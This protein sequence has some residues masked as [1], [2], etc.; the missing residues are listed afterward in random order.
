MSK[1]VEIVLPKLGESIL[2]ATVVQWLKKEGDEI[3]LDEAIVEVST[4]KVNSEIPSPVAGVLQK[5]CVSEGVEVEV[6]GL[7]AVVQT[8]EAGVTT[9]QEAQSIPKKEEPQASATNTSSKFYTPVVLK[10]AKEKG[11]SEE[12]LASIKRSGAGGRLSRKDL[13]KY[14]AEKGEAC[15]A[16]AADEK[17]IKMGAM[18]KMIAQNLVKSFYEAPHA[19]LVFD[20]DITSTMQF[21][22]KEKEAFLKE[23]GF[24]LTITAFLAQAIAKSVVKFPLINSSLKGDTILVKSNVNLGIAVSVTEGVI[25][26]VIQ[27]CQRLGIVDIAREVAKLASLSRDEKLSPDQVKEGTITMTNFGMSGAM[28]GIPII[29]FPEVA[30]VGVGSI[31]KEASVVDGEIVIRDK[32]KLSLTFDHR[33]IDGI[34][35]CDFLSEVKEFFKNSDNIRIS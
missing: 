24:K 25:V 27:H 21:I 16:V 19:S 20:I 7:I 29:R 8:A 22:K 11:V 35:G 5:I 32:V 33:V 34:Y 31:D 13:E 10:L 18:R 12:E 28:I 1:N 6:G 15:P 30:I 17:P 14:L 3:K 9:P 26:P 23:H 2:S 4:D